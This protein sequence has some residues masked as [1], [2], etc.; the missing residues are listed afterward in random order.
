MESVGFDSDLTIIGA[1]PAGSLAAHEAIYRKSGLKVYVFEEHL[2]EGLPVHCSGLISLKRFKKLGRDFKKNRRKFVLNNIRRSKFIGPDCNS[3]EIDR[4]QDSLAVMNR[5]ALD[6]YLAGR[7]KKLGC[8]YYLGHSV[9]QIKLVENSWNL[10]IKHKKGI[11]THRTR[12]LIS[13]EG[14]RAKL[15]GSVGLPT[16]NKNWLF[17][18]LQ[19]EF[20][21]VRNLEPDCVE[22]YFGQKYAPGFFGWVI[23][24][25]DESAR[26]GVGFSKWFGG[27]T[28]LYINQFLRKHP[29][30]KTRLR[31][32][33]KTRHYGGLIPV[34]GPINKTFFTNLMVVGDAAGQSKA[35][36]GGG[37]NIG[38]FC[39][40]LA[41]NIA[42]KIILDEVTHQKG[43]R[44][45]EKMWKA[46][47]EPNLS[48]MKLLRRMLTPL[49]DDS[50][51]K[52]IRIARDT[53]ME[54]YLQNSDIDLHGIDLLKY[55][56]TP[57]VFV[58][59]LN[60]FPQAV[61]S[62]LR[63]LSI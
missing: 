37:V 20:D 58:R 38:G 59:S 61:T 49:P 40:R 39:G 18:A 50:W 23:P 34:S 48:L 29:L 21:G 22:L 32:A 17:P 54:G 8:E 46:H 4:D 6:H 27:K 44:D 16:P 3:F 55:S 24:I 35:T 28:R 53:N 11:K 26:I 45:Y 60:L 7:A 33:V 9:R 36:T 25:S 30:L 43:C 2:K 42:R 12:I 14:T 62:L 41:G 56:L 5:V 63:G 31:N 10:Q 1:G 13:A 57:R 51:N 19:Y 15:T 47:F 52:I